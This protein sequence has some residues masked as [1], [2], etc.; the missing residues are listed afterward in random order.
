MRGLRKPRRPKDVSPHGQPPRPLQQAEREFRA[1]LPSATDKVGFARST[2]D[3]LEKSKLRA[4]LYV[5]QGA[6]CVYCECRVAERHPPPRIEHWRPLALNPELALH[7]PNLYLSCAHPATCDCRKHE[8]PLRAADGDPDLPWP[9][10]HHYEHC[11][12]FNSFGEIYVRSD[13]P[14]DDAQRKALVLAIGVPHDNETKD[15]G[16]L[17]LNHPALIEARRAAIDSERTRLER[18]FENRRASRS[19]REAVA[20]ERLGGD[21]LP[22]F[23]SIRVGWLRKTL[24]VGRA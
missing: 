7:W 14:L 8:S 9:V 16:I 12:G 21:T 2:F 5:E 18:R 20:T 6:L 11:V 19:E 4:V 3:S 24:G 13:A 22:E 10:D 1:V 15:N 23:V 17:N